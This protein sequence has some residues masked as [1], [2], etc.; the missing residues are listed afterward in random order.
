MNQPYSVLINGVR[1][2]PFIFNRNKSSGMKVTMS[3]WDTA[4]GVT[5]TSKTSEKNIENLG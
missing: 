1:N 5:G 4:T 3:F 2:M